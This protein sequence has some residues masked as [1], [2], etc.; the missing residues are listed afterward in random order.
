[1]KEIAPTVWFCFFLVCTFLGPKI[2]MFE[3]SKFKFE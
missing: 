1:M 3:L 2:F